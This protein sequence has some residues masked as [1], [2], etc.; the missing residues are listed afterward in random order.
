MA[1]LKLTLLEQLQAAEARLIAQLGMETAIFA[2][3]N[4]DV[5]FYRNDFFIIQNL[6]EIIRKYFP[7]PGDLSNSITTSPHLMQARRAFVH[8]AISQ[9]FMRKRQL[10]TMLNCSWRNV[11]KLYDEACDLLDRNSVNQTFKQKY[12]MILFEF[13]KFRENARSEN[14]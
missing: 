12:S 10:A 6:I 7:F 11:Y 2:I 3:D 13:K 8:I 9:M 1:E 5:D 14:T 4:I